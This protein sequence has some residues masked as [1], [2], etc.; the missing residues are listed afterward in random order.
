MISSPRD[1]ARSVGYHDPRGNEALA[2]R[3][4]SI[5]QRWDATR[6]VEPQV[7]RSA[8]LAAR[9]RDLPRFIRKTEFFESDRGSGRISCRVAKELDHR[10]SS[11]LLALKR[12][13]SQPR[14]ATAESAIT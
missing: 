11:L 9:Q 6:R 10:V 5:D 7:L 8:V 14:P 12:A 13:V 1:R 4:I 3:S 2:S